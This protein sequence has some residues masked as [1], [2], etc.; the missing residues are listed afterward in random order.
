MWAN[1]S[2]ISLPNPG[3][4]LCTD[5]FEGPSPQ[6]VNLAAKVSIAS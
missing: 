5:D 6:N 2:N 4:Q 1:Y 3:N